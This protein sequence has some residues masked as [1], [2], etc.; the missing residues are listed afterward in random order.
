[1]GAG[2]PQ[3]GTTHN[4]VFIATEHDSVYAFDADTNTG[5][6]ASPLWQITLLDAAHGAAAGATTVPN[7]DVSTRRYHPRNRNYGYSSDRPH[8]RHT[9]CRWENRG[10]RD[11]FQ[12]LHA[13]D[14][15]TGAE[16]FGG[17]VALQASV[18]GTGNGSSGSVLTFDHSMGEPAP[19]IAAAKWNR[20]HRFRR[21]RRQWAVARMGLAYNA[22]DACPD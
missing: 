8:D 9:L 7:S 18:P 15:T 1:M 12:R 20:V 4:V 10:E 3:A 14:V 17:P 19:G 5:A 22:D 6:N 21:A 11:V 2:T 13:L 16:K